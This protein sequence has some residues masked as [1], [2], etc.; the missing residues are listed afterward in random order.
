[1]SSETNKK[2]AQSDGGDIIR[3]HTDFEDGSM[4]KLKHGEVDPALAFANGEE[5]TFTPE[6]ERKVLWKVDRAILPL[7]MWIYALQFADKTSLNYASLMGIREDTGLN[8]KSQEYSWASSIF[9]AGYLL[10]EFPT[11]YLLRRL[12]LGKYTS[13]NITLWG[14]VLVCHVFAFNYAGLLS[15]RF[16]LGALE[17][18]VTPAFVILTSAWY[19]QNEQAKRMGYWLSCNG[20]ALL[21]LGPIAYGLSGA[22]NTVLATWK[23]LY[24]VLGLPTVITGVYCWWF[25][26]DNQ[27]N[28]KFLNHREKTIAI[29]RIRGNFQGIGSRKWK[30]DQFYEAFKDP[31]TYLYVLFSLLMNIPN[32]GIT[33]FGSIIINSFGFNSRLSLLLNMPTGFV[34]ITCKLLFTYLSDKFMDR[35]LFAF[36]AILIPMI[37]GIMM[38][39]IP[40]SAQGALL[41][42]YYLIGA[43]GSSW[44]L[45]MVMISNN[46]LGYTKKAT[47]NGLQI[48]A[49]GAGNWIG[50]QTFRSNE[51]PNYHNG[52]LMVAIMYGLAGC[53][54][55]AIRL[56]NIWENKRRDKKAAEEPETA[57]SGTEFLDLT[58]FEQPTFRY[59]L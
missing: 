20:V 4:E 31:R 32:G 49:Y 14:I 1:M 6:E 41:V 24:L 37:G 23:V 13:A 56:V 7:L 42:G 52:K 17:A 51:A 40:L 9:Y 21:T 35:S 59:V 12:P 27:T 36:I 46:T 18:T 44:C 55:V 50:P 38:I 10:W 58:D 15:V 16:F 48:L 34:D 25:M 39:V 2:T 43:A 33:A 5:V 22:H 11:T 19:K 26:P 53:T 45:V 47:V 28:A 3:T 8:P 30:W 29:E 57:V 54:I